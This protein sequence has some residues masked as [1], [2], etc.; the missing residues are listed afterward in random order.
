MTV[1]TESHHRTLTSGQATHALRRLLRTLANWH[2]A[3]RTAIA[4]HTLSDHQLRDI[5]LQRDQI[6]RAG[7]Y[8]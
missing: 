4:L 6:D 1:L 3:R 7:L 8:R 2:R 5:G